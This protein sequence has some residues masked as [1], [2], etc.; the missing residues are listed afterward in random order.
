MRL[1]DVT[2]EPRYIALVKYFVEARGT[3]PHF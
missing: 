2:Q 1:Y 3:Q